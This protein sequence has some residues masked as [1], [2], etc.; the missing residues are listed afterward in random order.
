MRTL[1][2]VPLL[3][4][5]CALSPAG[6][7]RAAEWDRPGWL[8]TFHDEFDGSSLDESR[9]VK[10]YKWG[11]AQVNG[12][13]QAYV[14]D[15]F[16]VQDGILAIV[17]RKESGSYAGETFQ[18]TSG[19][20]SSALEQRYGYFE[21]RLR[22][23]AGQGLW[24][25]FWLLHDTESSGVDEID[26]HEILGDAP[27]VAYMTN[28]WGTSY[29]AGE[30]FSDESSYTGPDFSAGFHVFGLEW[31]PDAIV[32]TIDGVERKRHTGAGVPQVPMYLILNL[33]IGGTWPGAPDGSTTFPARYEI[34][35]V[36]AYTSF[37]TPPPASSGG[38]GCSTGTGDPSALAAAV[39]LVALLS[40]RRRRAR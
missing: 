33:A 4:V 30:H 10:R 23:P 20:L 28:H 8:L 22:V 39:G 26:I 27:D 25:A 1:P 17:G 36:R 13:L 21:A 6:A 14:D 12:E 34:D 38:R 9:W 32:W 7:P 3:A 11:E 40:R 37:A 24:P 31:T 5:L 2:V 18:Y 29:A 35:Y 16:Q 19:V 15:A